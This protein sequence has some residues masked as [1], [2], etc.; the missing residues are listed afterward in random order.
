MLD[1]FFAKNP[2][3]KYI[4]GFHDVA[5]IFL[6]LFGNSTGYY[7]MEKAGRT[8]F[9]DFLSFEFGEVGMAV[10]KIVFE[11]ITAE[12]PEFHQIY[13]SYEQTQF[14]I[15]ILP[16]ILTWFS[17]NFSSVKTIC[18]IWDYLLSTGPHGVLYLTC[19][20]IL[21]TKR[22]LLESCRDELDVIVE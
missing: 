12:D 4:Q 9:Y 17:H 5:S 3:L 22:E 8:Y 18:R 16:W 19:G 15:F 21:S 10:S 1:S 14:L 2:D 6:I 7:L 20:I 11:I 13:S